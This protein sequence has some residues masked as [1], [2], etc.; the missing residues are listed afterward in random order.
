MLWHLA[1]CRRSQGYARGRHCQA[2]EA[3][4]TALR[5]R[6]VER[7]YRLSGDGCRGQGQR[8]Q[9][10]YVGSKSARLRSSWLQGAEHGGACARLF[11]AGGG[12]GGGA[13][14]GTAHFSLTL[15]RKRVWG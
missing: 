4:A 7:T 6:A 1:G 11:V 13:G 10:R 2:G 8:H 14:A 15:T 9:T 12:G 5:E 3:A